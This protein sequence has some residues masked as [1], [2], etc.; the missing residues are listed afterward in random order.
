[1]APRTRFWSCS[2]AILS[3]LR[4]SSRSIVNAE[5][6]PN[7]EKLYFSLMVSGAAGQDTSGVVPAV[8]RTLQDINSDPAILPGYS[9]HFTRVADTMVEYNIIIHH[10][11]NNKELGRV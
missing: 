6:T 9:L 4:P 1:M 10:F 5:V 3:I 7:I 11:Y 2:L 8:Q